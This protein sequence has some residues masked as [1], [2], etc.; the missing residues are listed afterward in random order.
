MTSI[1]N[2]TD[3]SHAD[4]PPDPLNSPPY[5]IDVYHWILSKF[6]PPE[7]DVM[8]FEFKRNST[9]DAPDVTL[10][11]TLSNQSG[12]VIQVLPIDPYNRESDEPIYETHRVRLNDPNGGVR[13][14][15]TLP[16]E[17]DLIEPHPHVLE[18]LVD[19]AALPVDRLNERL[20]LHSH[21]EVHSHDKEHV[22]NQSTERRQYDV[23]TIHAT[24]LTVLT[25]V[26]NRSANR[27]AQSSLNQF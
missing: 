1:I 19:S 10:S 16:D 8:G 2:R 3:N 6:T 23:E 12:T 14:Y 4:S 5:T 20:E 11:G 24:V 25:V 17:A 26:Q 21:P 15:V 13:A 22:E 27:Q 7:W 9:D 18:Q